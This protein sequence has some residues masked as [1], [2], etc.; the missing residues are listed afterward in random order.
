MPTAVGVPPPFAEDTCQLQ[1]NV[2]NEYGSVA[3]VLPALDENVL[4]SIQMILNPFGSIKYPLLSVL[5][6]EL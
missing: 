3:R 1:A 6:V 2:L 5:Y 4:I